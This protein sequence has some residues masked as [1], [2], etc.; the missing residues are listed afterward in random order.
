MALV[1]RVSRYEFDIE[2]KDMTFSASLNSGFGVLNDALKHN[3]WEIKFPTEISKEDRE[4]V[5]DFLNN[6]QGDYE[7]ETIN[8][9]EM[10]K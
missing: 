7:A 9:F 6:Y 2:F 3:D 4:I 10:E 5:E 1:S 8:I